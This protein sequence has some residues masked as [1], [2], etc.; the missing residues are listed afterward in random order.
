MT[1]HKVFL[2]PKKEQSLNRFHPWIFSGAIAHM[3]GKPEDILVNIDALQEIG[4]D[5]PF[6]VKFY[7]KMKVMY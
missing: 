5:I 4:L 7:L 3:E 2:K 6:D 1:T